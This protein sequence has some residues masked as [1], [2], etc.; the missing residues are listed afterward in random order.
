MRA[1]PKVVAR[2][3]FTGL[4]PAVNR[5][6]EGEIYTI[7]DERRPLKRQA[8]NMRGIDAVTIARRQ[9]NA[10][11]AKARCAVVVHACAG[12]TRRIDLFHD[13]PLSPVTRGSAAASAPQCQRR[14]VTISSTR[15]VSSVHYYVCSAALNDMISYHNTPPCRLRGLDVA[16]GKMARIPARQRRRRRRVAPSGFSLFLLSLHVRI[17]RRHTYARHART[18]YASAATVAYAARGGVR[19]PSMFTCA[20][21]TRAYARSFAAGSHRTPPATNTRRA[22]AAGTPPQNTRQNPTQAP[23]RQKYARSRHVPPSQN[24]TD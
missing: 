4:S 11:A 14:V 3:V 16:Q 21:R 6:A 8:T 9:R 23:Q 20:Y 5:C 17:T 7:T 19:L 24:N 10:Y 1:P 12:Q 15:E 2:A 13:L 22:A 18:P